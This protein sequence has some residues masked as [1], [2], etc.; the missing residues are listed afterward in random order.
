[1]P[2]IQLVAERE[3]EER[4]RRI[5]EIGDDP[6]GDAVTGDREKPD[7]GARFIDR[8]CDGELLDAIA[9][10]RTIEIDDRDSAHGA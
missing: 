9:P 1:M 10:T 5:P 8:A 2:R 3:R 7:G 4:V 6:I